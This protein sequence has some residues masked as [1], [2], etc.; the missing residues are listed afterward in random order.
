MPNPVSKLYSKLYCKGSNF[1]DNSRESY[2]LQ[3]LTK[4]R[5]W[6][7]KIISMCLFGSEMMVLFF[8]GWGTTLQSNDNCKSCVK[9]PFSCVAH[10]FSTF[11]FITSGPFVFWGLTRNKTFPT[12]ENTGCPVGVRVNISANSSSRLALVCKA[13]FQSLLTK[14]HKEKPAHWL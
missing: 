8:Q 11:P 2:S 7:Y 13:A 4:H 1:P 6:S 12:L 3:T 9:T 14:P 10:F 5:C